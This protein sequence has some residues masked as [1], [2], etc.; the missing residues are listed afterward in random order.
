MSTFIL[1]LLIL[2]CQSAEMRHAQLHTEY[3][4]TYDYP[5]YKCHVTFSYDVGDLDISTLPKFEY[6]LILGEEYVEDLNLNWV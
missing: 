5:E 6:T 1:T 4:L 3:D 2:D